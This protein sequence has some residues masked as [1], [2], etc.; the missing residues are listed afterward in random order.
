M[1]SMLAA[2]VLL[3]A[4]HG[5]DK[6][7]VTRVRASVGSAASRSVLSVRALT[8]LPEGAI[9]QVT[10]TPVR[11][12]Y[13]PAAGR[14]VPTRDGETPVSKRVRVRNGRIRIPFPVGR[15]GMVEIQIRFEPAR[16]TP[17]LRKNLKARVT[18]A[19]VRE[20][21]ILANPAAVRRDADRVSAWIKRVRAAVEAHPEGGRALVESL[22]KLRRRPTE[23]V[24]AEAAS[25]RLVELIVSYVLSLRPGVP[26]GGRPSDIHRQLHPSR[27]P[28][29][30][31][32]GAADPLAALRS[33]LERCDEIL[34][35]EQTLWHLKMIRALFEEL[36]AGRR[37]PSDL[38]KV[39]ASLEKSPCGG[40]D[41]AEVQSLLDR[42][43]AMAEKVAEGESVEPEI[44]K[45]VKRLDAL[46]K[47]VR[48]M[49]R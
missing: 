26:A 43:H 3:L 20:R 6:G 46:E 40:V 18:Y 24:L 31:S 34:S 12:S 13:D 22:R 23:G 14:I 28:K 25:Q 32:D 36:A 41:R 37:R 9:V 11:E 19:D 7:W 15:P 4:A 47:I 8:R 35:R 49:G 44:R 30:E 27:G 38:T 42:Y 5:S 17:A 29:E 1:M 48:G 21:I 10:V 16:Q 2:T 39:A 45:A 33:E